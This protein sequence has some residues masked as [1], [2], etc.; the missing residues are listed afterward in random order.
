MEVL[1][2]A[3]DY[4]D[5][6]FEIWKKVRPDKDKYTKYAAIQRENIRAAMNKHAQFKINKWFSVSFKRNSDK[7]TDRKTD[8]FLNNIFCFQ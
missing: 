4:A 2:K 6:A 3:Y 8:F 7:S 1:Q 5:W